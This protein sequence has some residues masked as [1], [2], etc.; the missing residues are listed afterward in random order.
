MTS[1]N[2]LSVR[3]PALFLLRVPKTQLRQT[4]LH[5]AQRCDD[6]PHTYCWRVEPRL[7]A[8]WTRELANIVPKILILLHHF[9]IFVSKVTRVTS[10]TTPPNESLDISRSALVLV[11]FGEH[12][13]LHL[14]DNTLSHPA[15]SC[16]VLKEPA[17]F[18]TADGNTLSHVP[19]RTTG[20]N[21]PCT[22]HPH[23]TILV[24][25]CTTYRRAECRSQH[26]YQIHTRTLPA[27]E[28][29]IITTYSEI[30]GICFILQRQT[31]VRRVYTYLQRRPYILRITFSVSVFVAHAAYSAMNLISKTKNEDDGSI[32]CFLSTRR[33]P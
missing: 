23:K 10:I 11:S 27:N 30:S 32:P 5:P 16:S 25:I 4:S 33:L 7:L 15:C 9:R 21:Y 12:S 8:F 20:K 3:F 31:S 13:V 6:S 1:L 26:F 22:Y 18:L 2:A 19:P 14:P 28:V 24:A 17:P 29:T